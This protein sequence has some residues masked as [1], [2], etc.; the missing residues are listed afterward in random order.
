LN[1]QRQTTKPYFP[2]YLFVHVD[3][4]VVSESSLRWIPGEIGLVCFGGEPAYVS[5]AILHAIRT[6]VDEINA[7]GGE[8]LQ[9]L[10]N[11]D[12]IAIHSGPF[13]G[14][15]GIFDTYLSDYKRATILLKF[16]RDQQIRVDLP[17][18]QI[19]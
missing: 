14:Y 16:I 11:G 12:P 15:Q 3:L 18:G 5:D 8:R 4:N 17:V 10:K 6:H 9:N 2:G 19:T 13:A 7:E 1:S